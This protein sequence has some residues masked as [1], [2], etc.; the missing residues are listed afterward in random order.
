MINEGK[1]GQQPGDRQ[2]DAEANP[3][4]EMSQNPL[5]PARGYRLGRGQ[6]AVILGG[7]LVMVITAAMS[8]QPSRSFIV[9][10]VSG[11]RFFG[12]WPTRYWEARLQRSEYPDPKVVDHLVQGGKDAVPVLFDLLDSSNHSVRRAAAEAISRI[13]TDTEEAGPCLVKALRDEDLSVG[14]A[15]VP[16]NMGVAAKNKEVLGLLLELA[17]S[18]SI[19][20]RGDG[21]DAAKVASAL[22]S[23]GPEAKAAVPTMENWLPLR[24]VEQYET[25]H[26]ALRAIDP[27]AAERII[28]PSPSSPRKLQFVG[29]TRDLICQTSLGRNIYLW[30]AGKWAHVLSRVEDFSVL[31][32]GRSLIALVDI[33]SKDLTLLVR[34]A[35]QS[36][37]VPKVEWQVEHE[38]SQLSVSADGQLVVTASTRGRLS[39]FD[40]AT[41]RPVEGV[42]LPGASNWY[43]LAFST[44]GRDLAV[45][46]EV[47]NRQ[48]KVLLLDTAT[49]AVRR[50]HEMPSQ[51]SN[52][53]L[54]NDGTV[55]A[56]FHLGLDIHIWDGP[57]QRETIVATECEQLCKIVTSDSVMVAITGKDA[58]TVGLWN[59]RSGALVREL[60]WHRRSP[61]T[62]VGIEALAVS[63]DGTCL[64]S[65]DSAGWVR[66]WDLK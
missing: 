7:I 13:A 30:R 16:L 55:I 26:N 10:T 64:A 21:S 12:G 29:D 63:R 45:G 1:G 33:A 40:V 51:P 20:Q 52:I 39:A 9:G 17:Q 19:T 66:L 50:K 37:D 53:A 3:F 15:A 61:G 54:A 57:T 59:L 4:R 65:M 25:I 11:D 46:G 42:K 24:H 47:G 36:G 28:P 8:L 58:C 18:I 27:G 38:A 44:Q 31:P 43:A 48:Y 34:V 49:G 41:G 14:V 32:D 56:A 2:G 23:F 22:A 35:L 6:L 60:R 5:A 62:G